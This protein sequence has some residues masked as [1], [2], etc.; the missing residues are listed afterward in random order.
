MLTE[1]KWKAYWLNKAIKNNTAD[2]IMEYIKNT[3]DEDIETMYLE[4]MPLILYIV[5]T[6]KTL[7]LPY[8]EEF[9]CGG[10]IKLILDKYPIK[11]KPS[12]MSIMDCD[13]WPF[14]MWLLNSTGKMHASVIDYCIYAKLYD[15]IDMLI[16]KFGK[17]LVAGEYTDGNNIVFAILGSANK[18]DFDSAAKYCCSIIKYIDIDS[19]DSKG[20]T[21]LHLAAANNSMILARY[22]VENKANVNAL[23]NNA[24]TPLHLAVD[25]GNGAMASY[26]IH[27]G[28]VI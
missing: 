10:K 19:A 12:F 2:K 25:T 17:R 5:A 16:K 9:V 7:A 11:V 26:L 18:S 3:P 28:A 1:L 24:K 14:M 20:N 6:L 13:E 21:L 15:I 4:K 22:L 27:N 8:I 23:N